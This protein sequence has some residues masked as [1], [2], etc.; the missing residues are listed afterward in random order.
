MTEQTQ[1]NTPD[2]SDDTAGELRPDAKV[3]TKPGENPATPATGG[4]G[5]AGAGGPAGFGGAN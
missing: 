2:R 3:Q 5:A 4:K 1:E